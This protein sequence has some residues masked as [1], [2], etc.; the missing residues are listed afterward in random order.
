MEISENRPI[1]MDI[2]TSTL[3]TTAKIHIKNIRL[4]CLLHFFM[5]FCTGFPALHKI[6][7]C[8]I[9]IINRMY[10]EIID[11][12]YPE[13]DE[14]K[15]TLIAHSRDVARKALAIASAHP[16]LRLDSRFLEEAAMLHDIGIKWTDAPG[17][18]CNG[19]HPYIC[20]GIIGGRLLRGEGYPRHAS[21]C[22]RHTG[23]GLTL[24][25]IEQQ[26]LPLPHRD[27][28]PQTTEEKVICYADKFFS[29]SSLGICRTVEQTVKSL[30]K[31]G[32]EGVALFRQWAGMFE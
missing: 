22:E 2:A 12:F 32:P 26:A 23:T 19:P 27:F 3:H 31:F 8:G 10:Q 24:K 15:K 4:L 21:V 6:L 20:H 17:I 30:E 18:Y 16:E 29:K 11:K 5:Y 25:Q 13:D 9:K 1:Y 28:T 7:C 14:L